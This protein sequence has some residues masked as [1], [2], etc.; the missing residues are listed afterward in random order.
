MTDPAQR[1]LFDPG[2]YTATPGFVY[3]MLLHD[4]IVKIGYSCDPQR[5]ARELRARLLG[6]CPGSFLHEREIHFELAAY[7]IGSH[8]DFWPSDEVWTA[9]R[10]ITAKRWV[11]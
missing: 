4:G 1:T 8:E 3:A 11:A 2:P 9:V 7:R 10:R 6:F 5:R